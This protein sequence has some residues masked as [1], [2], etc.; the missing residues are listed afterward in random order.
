M[1]SAGAR[2]VNRR[3]LS[4]NAARMPMPIWQ[5]AAFRHPVRVHTHYGDAAWNWRLTAWALLAAYITFA[6]QFFDAAIIAAVKAGDLRGL[7]WLG[8]LSDLGKFHWYLL[9]AAGA[10]LATYVADWQAY[11]RRGRSVLCL[12]RGQA[13]FAFA[14][15]VLTFCCCNALK[16]LI[17]RARPKFLED[18]GPGYFSPMSVGYSF[19]SFPSGHAT[20]LGSVAGILLIWM[21][22]RA[23]LI[24]AVFASVAFSRVVVRA[25]YPADVVAGFCLGLLMTIYLARWMA[26]R[27]LAFRNVAKRLLPQVR[28]AA[29][30]LAAFR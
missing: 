29:A 21:P 7:A 26:V 23:I 30:L 22:S 5:G 17:G 11:G 19:A 27:R 20:A 28:C 12:I 16:I 3:R 9:I 24:L 10:G 15:L 6:T 1:D 4:Q 13:L 25:H 2:A 14:S 8:R 18:L